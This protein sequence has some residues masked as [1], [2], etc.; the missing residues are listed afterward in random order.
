MPRK[1][2]KSARL[3]EEYMLLI[4]STLY[5]SGLRPLELLMWPKNGISL[6]LI[7][8]L[9]ALKWRLVSQAC[10]MNAFRFAL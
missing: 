5:G 10:S 7:L 2:H 8:H 1:V 4:A 6:H 9:S 3:V